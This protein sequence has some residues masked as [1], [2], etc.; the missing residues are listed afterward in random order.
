M[1]HNF[2][3]GDRVKIV[4]HNSPYNKCTGIVSS[5]AHDTIWIRLSNGNTLG[6]NAENVQLQTNPKIGDRVRITRPTG[7]WTAQEGDVVDIINNDN[8]VVDL[9]YDKPYFEA[10]EL[11]V[12]ESARPRR[13]EGRA[14]LNE[15]VQVGDVVACTT[16]ETDNAVQV[17]TTK[18]G[19]VGSAMSGILR[20]TGGYLLGTS[21]S[22]VT[23]VKDIEKD[24]ILVALR[25][26]P[27]ETI[28][29]YRSGSKNEMIVVVKL[30]EDAWNILSPGNRQVAK[31]LNL[32]ERLKRE[33]NDIYTVVQ[34]GGK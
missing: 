22:E 1:S 32:R 29:S 3:H 12:I 14:I 21:N 15:D 30:G 17:M 23:L 4:N 7:R 34:V 9:D 5:Y 13:V 27:R 2:S 20:T 19:T 31:T 10:N 33:A 25:Q 28:I 8:Y 26:L 11:E 16:L 6:F 24:E 18:T